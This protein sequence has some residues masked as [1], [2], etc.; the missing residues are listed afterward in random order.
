MKG[1]FYSQKGCIVN[2][3]F[4]VENQETWYDYLYFEEPYIPDEDWYDPEQDDEW[5]SE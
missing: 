3:D 1:I 4:Y 2:E 5:E